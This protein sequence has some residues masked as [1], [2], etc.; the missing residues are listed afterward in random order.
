MSIEARAAAQRSRPCAIRSEASSST[1]SPA[2]ATGSRSGASPSRSRTTTWSS[3]AAAGMG[4]PP[5]ITSP[6]S[7]ASPMSRCWRR[8]TS[9]R[10]NVGRNTTIIRSNYLLPGNMPFYEWSMKLWE[11]LEQDL[12]Y[13]AMVSQRGVLNL[14][15]F[16][17]AARRL[18]AARQRHAAARRRCR[19]ARPRAGARAW[20]RS[21][22]STM[23][24]FRSTAG[25]CSG[26]AAR[27]GTTRSPGAMRARADQRGVDIIQNCEVTGIR[28]EN[29]RVI[30]RRDRRAASSAP[31]RS[32]LA[33][34]RQLLAGRRDGGAAAADREPC[35]AGLR[36]GGHQAADRH[37]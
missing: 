5:P 3:S 22:I 4:S 20:C 37:A 23:R 1:R 11:G 36:L 13:N 26:A 31:T 7:T 24:A 9:A 19:A 29:G 33:V 18:C 35:A 6:R 30:G 8:A 2:T 17:R 25:C 15:P 10:G 21:S 12:N 28:I 27:C 32:A 34:R 16:R 14:Y